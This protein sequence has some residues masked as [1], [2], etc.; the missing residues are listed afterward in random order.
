MSFKNKLLLCV[1]APALA[2]VLAL[3]LLGWTMQRSQSE[4]TRYIEVDQAIQ[5]AL[6]DMYAQGL[7]MGQALRN[8]VLDPENK[9]A[10]GNLTTAQAQFGKSQDSLEQ[11]AAGSALAESTRGLGGMR[12]KLAA[13]Q[14]A[15]L[16]LVKTDTTAAARLLVTAETPAWRDLRGA[17]LNQIEEHNKAT[18]AAFEAGRA[19]VARLQVVSAGLALL[20][21]VCSVL[22]TL[23]LLRTVR[24][25]LGTE[26]AELRAA[27]ASL[28]AGD[29]T[30]S[31]DAQPARPGEAPSVGDALNQT[32]AQ[33]KQTIGGVRERAVAITQSSHEIAQ[34]NHDLSAR[35]EQTASNL[36]ETA[37]SME[38]MSGAVR[39]AAESAGTANRLAQVA[40][41][42]AEQ[43]GAVVG[44]VVQTMQDIND[45]S[46]RI[47]DIIGVIDGISFQ[48]NILALNAAVEAA[49]AGEQG[50]GFAVVAGE[51]RT[52]AQRS[53]QA[54]R[55]IKELIGNSVQ[56]VDAGHALVTQAGATMG[57]IVD[58][59]KRV[60]DIIG[61][62]A[63]S[64][65]EQAEGVNQINAAVANLDQMTQQNAALVEQSAA[66]ASSMSEQANQ[67][68]TLVEAFRLD[69]G[70]VV[71]VAR[72]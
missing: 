18:Q 48:T 34:G 19:A 11:L 3:A 31:V 4:F 6:R 29:L 10:Y 69:R 59:V 27:M 57:E 60:R 43:G 46:R 12:D 51:V 67:L 32:I 44:Q 40:G 42:S 17:L 8:I 22:F 54:A 33:L 2:F 47:A 56:R 25:E 1:G 36:E 50:R 61:E 39:Q 35:T 38:E 21:L 55:E 45:A 13:Q 65:A 70:G 37:A 72:R 15:V 41:Q 62:I 28:A 16:A 24:R 14:Q 68:S 66:A 7:Q 58:N 26:P 52:L 49:R 63:S 20:A 30:V 64:S 9:Q 53:A 71:R 5:V 23:S